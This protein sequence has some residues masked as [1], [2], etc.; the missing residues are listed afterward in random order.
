[1]LENGG[2]TALA[3]G[4]LPRGRV[5]KE[6]FGTKRNDLQPLGT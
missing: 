5:R 3:D 6:N 4:I 2:N 1:M